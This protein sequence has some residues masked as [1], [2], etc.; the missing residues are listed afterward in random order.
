ME[1]WV[2]YAVLSMM[3]AGF[4][5]VI[6]KKGLQGISGELGLTIRTCFVFVFVMLFVWTS[7]G[8]D[9]WNGLERKHYLWLGLSGVA[10]AISWVFYYKALAEGNVST[11]ALIDKGSFVVALI[12][13]WLML[14]EAITWRT[15]VGAVLILAG[16]FVVAWKPGP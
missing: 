16:L 6:A 11:V 9:Q 13:A 4:T 2:V 8:K 5:S 10:T 12:L 14:G 7:V 1:R 3:A 15:A